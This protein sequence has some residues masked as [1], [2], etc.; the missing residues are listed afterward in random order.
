MVDLSPA[1]E[2]VVN[3]PFDSKIFLSGAAGTGKTT[4][5][6]ARLKALLQGG[7]PAH[8]VSVLL[9]QR[10]L[11]DPYMSMLSDPTLPGGT[12]VDIATLGGL[13]RRACDLFWPLV[14][15]EHGFAQPEQRPT[16]LSLE[17]AQY[18]MARLIG[19]ELS[20]QGYFQHVKMD[21]NRL[22][23]Q[24]ID[25]LNKAAVIDAFE[26]T[27]IS[28]RLK[29]A[30]QGGVEQLQ[31]YDD[32]QVAANQFREF[33]LQHNLL[34][35]SLQIEIFLK[36]LWRLDPVR[37][38]V[39]NGARHV[40]I[41]NV[42]EDTPAA[43]VVM[44][45]IIE[46]A[47]SALVIYDEDAGY[48]RFLGADEESA[49]RQLADVCDDFPIFIESFVMPLTVDSLG[50][51][52]AQSMGFDAADALTN[53]RDAVINIGADSPDNRYYTE[54]IDDAIEQIAYLYH[55]QGVPAQ[56]MVVISPYVSDSLRFSLMNRL[57]VVDVPVRSHR[58]SRSLR[59]EPATQCMLTLAQLAHPTWGI[60][61]LS[62]D[63]IY[64][65]M[66][67][68][69]DI[70]LVRAQIIGRY[71]YL[72]EE[73]QPRLKPFDALTTAVQERI[74]YTLGE[75]YERLRTWVGYATHT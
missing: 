27:E 44:R 62:F 12:P 71:A 24:V 21:P 64:M 13:A 6:V 14:A 29:A 50:S 30:W 45:E 38:W 57:E 68:L 20:R 34:D 54:M 53:P 25:N 43:H 74:T 72:V 66:E 18:F 75:R 15:E 51:A 17:T 59:Q 40:I 65:L 5:G 16:F 26:Y 22:Y 46:S 52:L 69:A 8:E 41:D 37:D 63:V 55:E 9:P 7:I 60:A 31:T 47:Q 48:R 3:S 19:P 42:E 23:S 28:E 61:P 70:D 33:C 67:A 36:R 2:R 49:T 73:G 35:F 32:V 4:T 39:F 58:P 11:A 10:T 1:Q 56:E